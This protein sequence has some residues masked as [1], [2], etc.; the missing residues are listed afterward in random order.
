M[1]SSKVF[2]S[3]QSSKVFSGKRCTPK[4]TKN[5]LNQTAINYMLEA[6]D[7]CNR[8]ITR[9]GMQEL[10]HGYNNAI[11]VLWSTNV[12]VD[13]INIARGLKWITDGHM[14]IFCVQSA[15]GEVPQALLE[16]RLIV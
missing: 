4:A 1:H 8:Y 10:K 13:N 14:G 7:T 5:I 11:E 2:K 6:Y 12:F 16:H 3:H 15:N 9:P